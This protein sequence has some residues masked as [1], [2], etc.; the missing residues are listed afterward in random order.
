MKLICRNGWWVSGKIDELDANGLPNMDIRFPQSSKRALDQEDYGIVMDHDYLKLCG[1]VELTTK[2]SISKNAQ[3]FI[4]VRCLSLRTTFALSSLYLTHY[5]QGPFTV[6]AGGHLQLSTDTETPRL[7]I[8]APC[9][10]WVTTTDDPKH[11]ARFDVLPGGLVHVIVCLFI[12]P[13]L[14]SNNLFSKT[15]LCL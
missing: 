7:M 4:A 15:L 14:S 11:A 6:Q 9:S 10:A 5:S 1:V 13:F 8:S 12:F 3:L 2:L